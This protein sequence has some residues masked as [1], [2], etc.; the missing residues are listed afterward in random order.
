ML[1]A[2]IEKNGGVKVQEVATPTPKEGE[3]LLKV[4]MAALCGTDQRVLRGEKPVSVPIIGHE[5]SGIVAAV[6]RGVRG[7]SE[8]ERHAVQTVIGCGSCPMCRKDRQNLCEVGFKAIGYHWNGGFAEYFV[9]PREG[10]DQGCLIPIADSMSASEATLLEPVSC[11]VNGLRYFPM[12]EM[13]HIVVLGAGIIGVLNGLAARARGAETVTIMNRSQGRLDLIE[14][15]GLPFDHL[16][17]ISKTD[18]SEWV[19]GHTGGRGVDG[20]IVSASAKE[21]APVALNLLRRGGHLSLFAGMPKDDP[22]E[23]IDLNLIH[24]LELNVHGANSSVRRDYEEARDLLE[25]KMSA[26]STLFTHTFPLAEFNR[27]L[28]TQSDPNIPSLKVLIEP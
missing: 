23:A 15:L 17:N 3:V 26:A 9:M 2:V 22:I 8:G 16:I 5:I 24:Y 27:A 20:A 13:K 10:V 25:T 21:L 7:V 1:A 12:E 19:R 11:C 14:K 18:P 28:A 4:E 6:G